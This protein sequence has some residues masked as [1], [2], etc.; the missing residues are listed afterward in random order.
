MTP[1]GSAGDV[2]DGLRQDRVPRASSPPG[3]RWQIKDG[4]PVYLCCRV[5]VQR[6]TQ[7]AVMVEVIVMPDILVV[8]IIEI[9]CGSGVCGGGGVLGLAHAEDIK[10][11]PLN[12]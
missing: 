7:V 12:R 2:H 8:G 5:P 6:E 3:Q 9:G 1:L 11:G 10:S 4:S